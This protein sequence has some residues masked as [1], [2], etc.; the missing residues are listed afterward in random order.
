MFFLSFSFMYE[1]DVCDKPFADVVFCMLAYFR[2]LQ[3]KPGTAGKTN[4][5]SLSR[6][7][8][9]PTGKKEWLMRLAQTPGTCECLYRPLGGL[10]V[11]CHS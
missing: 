3:K 10:E 1:E 4:L 7:V 6:S 11:R 9:M 2:W 5:T 8:A